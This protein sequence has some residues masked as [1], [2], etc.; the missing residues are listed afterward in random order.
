MCIMC[1]VRGP[2]IF[3]RGIAAS[4]E[5]KEQISE[6]VIKIIFLLELGLQK[7]TLSSRNSVLI[8]NNNQA[9]QAD[10]KWKL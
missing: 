9:C 6:A 5:E 1:R 2:C 8:V 3:P 10:K 7:E 4:T